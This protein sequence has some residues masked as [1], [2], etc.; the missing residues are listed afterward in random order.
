MLKLAR[1]EAVAR[2]TYV[3]V[4]FEAVGT[5][6][7]RVACVGA[8]DQDGSNTQASNLFYIG[9]VLGVRG[10]SLVEWSGLRQA[11]RDA[12]ASQYSTAIA[13]VSVANA[14]GGVEFQT[15]NVSFDQRKSITFT[16]RGQA[17][18]EGVVTADSGYDRYIDVSFRQTKGA[19]GEEASVVINGATG[20]MEVIR[21]P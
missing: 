5:D 4:G 20:G 3:W 6:E 1:N 16:P 7:V 15:R 14:G 21:R 8:V 18:V 9:K 10:V 13:P 19:A 12:A 11:T 2:Q 17:M